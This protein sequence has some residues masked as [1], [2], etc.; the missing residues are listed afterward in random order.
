M[1]NRPLSELMRPSRP[2]NISREPKGT[3]VNFRQASAKTK[4]P[5]PWIKRACESSDART[6]GGRIDLAAVKRWVA[7]NRKQLEATTGELS[8]R[9]QKLAEEVRRLR[10][11][12]DRD[13]EKLVE[14]AWIGAKMMEAGGRSN[15]IYMRLENELPPKLAEL[16]GD[17]AKI[18]EAL[19]AG[20]DGVR[21]EI[22]GL[23][24]IFRREGEE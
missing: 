22:Q 14:T 1:N 3:A 20:L 9:D 8:L 11:R 24:E 10:L 23:A 17:I 4:I 16:G 19:R 12:N 18:R 13:A 21:A 6:P 5:V 15:Q 7:A 2:K